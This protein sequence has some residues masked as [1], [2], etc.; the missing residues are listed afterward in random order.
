MN[1][2]S[3]PPLQFTELTTE[4]MILHED[5]CIQL[6]LKDKSLPMGKRGNALYEMICLFQKEFGVTNK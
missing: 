4:D 6:L 1:K 2:N 5:I 3:S